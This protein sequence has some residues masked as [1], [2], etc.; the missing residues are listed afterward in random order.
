MDNGADRCGLALGSGHDRREDVAMSAY[1]WEKEGESDDWFTPKYIFD[2]MGT[3][4]FMD[5]A[6]PR[7]GPRYTPCIDWLYEKS[8][9]TKWFDFVFMNPPYGKRG[10]DKAAWT[11]KFITHGNG[12]M[13]V[14]D[15]T[16]AGWFQEAAQHASSVLFMAPK[17]KFERPDGSI[18]DKPSNGTALMAAGSRG[19]AALVNARAAG[20]GWLCRGA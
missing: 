10:D 12:V 1:V 17:V 16:S 9:D 3:V 2:A 14:P 5:V 6:A 8:L 18:G 15:R 11:K 4:F 7:E 19:D 13:L 20:L